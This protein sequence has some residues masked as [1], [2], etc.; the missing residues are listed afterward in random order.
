MVTH[1]K[2][3]GTAEVLRMPPTV[4]GTFTRRRPRADE[5]RFSAVLKVKVTPAE[6][7]ATRR[8]ATFR[9]QTPSA[10]VRELVARELRAAFP[11]SKRAARPRVTT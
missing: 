11:V 1:T 8:L 6:L 4:R 10:M 5:E 9:K 7:E 3:D 2:D